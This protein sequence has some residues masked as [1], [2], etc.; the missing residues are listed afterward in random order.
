MR[1]VRQDG[2]EQVVHAQAQGHSPWSTTQEI[3]EG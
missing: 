2:E 1:V 3:Q